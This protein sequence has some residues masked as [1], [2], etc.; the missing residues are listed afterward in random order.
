MVYPTSITYELQKMPSPE[1]ESHRR[2]LQRKL[3]DSIKKMV[4]LDDIRI[5]LAEGAKVNEPVV[6]GLRPLHY[7]VW[8]RYLE[9]TQLLLTR[10]GDVNAVDECGYSPLH[11]S[12]E[13]GYTEV[14]RLLLKCGAK[15]DYRPETGEEFP[16]TMQGDE[17][18]RLAI[19]NKHMDI[20][21]LLL[22]HGADPNKRYFFG[23]E[24]NLVTDLDFLELLLNFGANP[25]SRDR[26]GL[27]PLMKAV[28]QGTKGMPTAL[29]LLK[30]G[31]DVNAITDERN[32]FRTVLHYAVSSG[33][34]DMINLVIKQGARLNYEEGYDFEKPSPLDLAILKGDPKIV[35]LL[36]K[37]GADV[38]SSSPLI[39][40]PLHVASADHI[41]NRYE[42]LQMLL[43]AGANPNLKVFNDI[44]VRNSQLRPVLVEYLARN[45]E[46]DV[47]IVD[48]LLKY[49]AKVIMKTQFRDPDGILN[50][51]ENVVSSNSD[52]VFFLLLEAS[53][54][55]DPCMIRRNKDLTPSQKAALL[56]LARYPLSLR[57]QVRL[58]LRRILGPNLLEEAPKWDIPTCLIKYLLFEY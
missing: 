46:P 47:R 6:Q 34:Y 58:Y 21:R 10:G 41:L 32:D 3:A 1:C 54:A 16:K 23:A 33:N 48:L 29:L 22:E 19:R 17:P 45:E 43:K 50:S 42:I 24:I 36:I 35:E 18:L 49:G 44:N 27:T 11:L 30:Y 7:A 15:V 26:C 51:L 28:R 31:A 39:G 8:Q 12:A 5:I 52:A 55:F 13:Y 9:A 56:E 25:D 38:N 40:S 4:P 20:A 37:S 2:A 53:E 14:V 57:R